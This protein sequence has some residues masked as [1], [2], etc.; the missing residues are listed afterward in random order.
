MAEAWCRVRPVGN[1]RKTP[2][3]MPGD[4]HATAGITRATIR[5]S[6]AHRLPKSP[7]YL[8]TPWLE[9]KPQTLEIIGLFGVPRMS[10]A[11]WYES[12]GYR[13]Q[14]R[15]LMGRRVAGQ[16]FLAAFA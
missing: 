6:E 2:A 16:G 5:L 7:A 8:S 12:D 3:T 13:P 14:G 11:I 4:V 1:A 15:P 9:V 10:A